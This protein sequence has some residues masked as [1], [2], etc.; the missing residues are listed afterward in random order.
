MK[1]LAILK[2]FL[3]IEGESLS[4]FAKQLKTLTDEDK[5]ELAR[6][7]ARILGVEVED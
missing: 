4:D 6:D 5:D 2:H 1:R 3:Q 7:G